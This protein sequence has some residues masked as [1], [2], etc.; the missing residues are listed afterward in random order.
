LHSIEAHRCH[1]HDDFFRTAHVMLFDIELSNPSLNSCKGFEG[2]TKAIAKYVLDVCALRH[3][4][5][6]DESIQ[7]QSIITH[8]FKSLGSDGNRGAD[9][10]R[11]PR[12]RSRRQ[13]RK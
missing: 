9:Q 11:G 13:R 4:A 3:I 5:D 8:V 6:D 2:S 10:Q 1:C 7:S 12:V